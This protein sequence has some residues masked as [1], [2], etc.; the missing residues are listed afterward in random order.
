MKLTNKITLII[1]PSFVWKYVC[2]VV[3][4]REGTNKGKNKG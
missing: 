3:V 1:R 2:L 4:V